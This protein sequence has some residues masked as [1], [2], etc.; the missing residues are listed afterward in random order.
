METREHEL[1]SYVASGSVAAELG[2]ELA[3]FRAGTV[4]A[5]QGGG[6]D[7]RATRLSLET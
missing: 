1:V 3:I 7:V 4:R 6:R 5:G 2:R